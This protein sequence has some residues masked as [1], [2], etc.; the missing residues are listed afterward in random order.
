MRAASLTQCWPPE[1]ML[2]LALIQ[3]TSGLSPERNAADVAAQARAAAAQG[4]QFILTP[5]MTGL[6]DGKRERM[7]QQ[8]RGE[9]DDLTLAVLRDVARETGAWIMLGSVPILQGDKCANR[10]FLISGTGDI[11][12]RYDKIH[13]FDVDLPNGERY[14]ESNS[15][16]AGDMSVLAATPWGALGLTICYDVRF[17]QLYRTLAKAG[18]AMITVPAAFTHTTGEAHWHVLLRARAIETGCYILAPAQ[19]GTHEDGRRTFGHS[20]VISPWGE[21]LADGGTEPGVVLADIDLAQVDAVRARIPSLIH[22]RDF[23]VQRS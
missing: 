1:A 19:C 3:M 14:R 4:A 7:M 2:R 22:D 10:A 21:I 15:Y 23:T 8:A 11:I 16:V 5:E 18:A 13:R 9:D 6:L 20:L 12:A 17:A